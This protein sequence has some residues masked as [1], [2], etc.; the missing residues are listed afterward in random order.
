MKKTNKPSSKISMCW[1]TCAR[2]HNILLFFIYCCCCMFSFVHDC[3]NV[4]TYTSCLSIRF[5]WYTIASMCFWAFVFVYLWIPLNGE[6][7]MNFT[8]FFFCLVHSIVWQTHKHVNG[9]CV[10][11]KSIYF[12]KN[13]FC[14][15]SDIR[16]MVRIYSPLFYFNKHTLAHALI[17]NTNNV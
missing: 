13:H 9:E 16:R 17:H 14:F 1:N 2:T 15:L 4:Y 8:L 11:Y 6:Y 3:I 10:W 7:I 12:P 5:Q